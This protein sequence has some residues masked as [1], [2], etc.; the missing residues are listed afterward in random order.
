M[1]RLTERCM[2]ESIS[3]LYGGIYLLRKRNSD[4]T[5]HI[6]V[7]PDVEDLLTFQAMYNQIEKILEL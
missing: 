3:V 7:Q 2:K 5:I 4:F 6:S 1:N